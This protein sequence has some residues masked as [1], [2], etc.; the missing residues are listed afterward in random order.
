MNKGT[1]KKKITKKFLEEN[2]FFDKVSRTRDGTFKIRKA[3][4]YRGGMT[5]SGWGRKVI[6]QLREAGIDARLVRTE[7][8]WKEWPKT[9]YFMAE[10]EIKQ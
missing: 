9:S 10:V 6:S 1:K 4:F 3:F 7:E 2:F 5:A 8:E